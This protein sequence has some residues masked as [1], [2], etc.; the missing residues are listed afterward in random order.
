MSC[1]KHHE[2]DCAEVLH[3]VYVYIDRELD[4]GTLTYEQIQQH[5]DE[6]GPCLS[7]YDIDRVVKALVARSCND[8][9][10]AELRLRVLARIHELRVEI[11][12][13]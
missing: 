12:G 8:R 7:S 4:E 6:C 1:G 9:A 3:R 10:P 13:T 2:V 11:S 5:L